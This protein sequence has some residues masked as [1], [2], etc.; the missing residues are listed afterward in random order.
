MVRIASITP[1]HAA[2]VGDIECDNARCADLIG[3]NVIPEKISII[4]MSVHDGVFP[5]GTCHPK[6]AP[7]VATEMMANI[8]AQKSTTLT[9]LSAGNNNPAT[10][11]AA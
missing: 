5:N 8:H 9:I 4:I 3:A 6:T 1:A 10:I 7:V 11:C 2:P